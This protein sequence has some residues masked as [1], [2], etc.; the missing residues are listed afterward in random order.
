M[1]SR[2]VRSNGGAP[3]WVAPPWVGVPPSASGVAANRSQLP[4][5]A[6]LMASSTLL[7]RKPSQ[8]GEIPLRVALSDIN[9]Q[10]GHS[11][12]VPSVLTQWARAQSAA[13]AG[14]RFVGRV[15][16]DRADPP[17]Y[18][19]SGSGPIERI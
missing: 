11:L 4:V 2:R 9:A 13:G 17:G 3:G 14:D 6:L 12:S 1:T 7:S 16:H 15:F 5:S 10:V 8:L 18:Q 19:L